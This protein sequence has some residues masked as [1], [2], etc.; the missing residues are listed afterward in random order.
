L[1]AASREASPANSPRLGSQQ[2][3]AEDE[4]HVKRAVLLCFN[5]NVRSFEDVLRC[6]NEFIRDTANAANL[7]LSDKEWHTFFGRD[8]T[9]TTMAWGSPGVSTAVTRAEGGVPKVPDVLGRMTTDELSRFRTTWCAKRY[10]H[11]RDQC[12][13]AHVGVNG[14]WLRRN[15]LSYQYRPEMCPSVVGV[16]DKMVSPFSFMLNECEKGE[17]CD[18][19]HSNEEVSYHPDRY[20]RK[21]CTAV[22]SKGGGCPLGD[23]CPD[24]HTSQ[25]VPR[26]KR[27]S[28]PDRRSHR[29]SNYKGPHGH[30]ASGG[31]GVPALMPE[32]SPMIYVEPAPVSSF[33]EHLGPPGLQSLFR[34][35]SSVVAGYVRHGE[36]YKCCYSNF[37]DDSGIGLTGQADLAKPSRG[38][39]SVSSTRS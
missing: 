26:G 3:K 19:A 37:G 1:T 29:A 24:L 8:A 11:D 17:K 15:P 4:G 39:P 35:H 21:M 23:I 16:A 33:E 2:S 9:K 25:N 30:G 32:G 10:E 13:F 18:F 22:S 38:L 20:K 7:Q 14:G 12:A 28:S 36:R 31:K 5:E 27:R 6:H 34:R